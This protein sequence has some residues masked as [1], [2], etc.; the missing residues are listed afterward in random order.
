M[1]KNNLNIDSIRT[2]ISLK[3]SS[4]DLKKLKEEADKQERSVSFLVSKMIEEALK[5]LS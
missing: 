5:K 1:S 4:D 3:L 2:T